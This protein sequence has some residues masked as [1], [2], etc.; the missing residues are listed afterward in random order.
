MDNCIADPK[1]LI[2]SHLGLSNVA[3]KWSITFGSLDLEILIYFF[4]LNSRSV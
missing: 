2:C 3:K 1:K 4:H